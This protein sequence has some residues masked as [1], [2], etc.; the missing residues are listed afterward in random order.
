MLEK[1]VK[2]VQSCA[3]RTRAC[4]DASCLIVLRTGQSCAKMLWT[5]EH[6]ETCLSR[7]CNEFL[8][9]KAWMFSSCK[10]ERNSPGAL[11]VCLKSSS[12]GANEAECRWSVV[13]QQN[14]NPADDDTR[15]TVRDTYEAAS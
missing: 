6:E 9:V 7:S 3:P 5:L 12:C 14:V 11:H 4:S 1:L 8:C 10:G 15:M 2:V 13:G